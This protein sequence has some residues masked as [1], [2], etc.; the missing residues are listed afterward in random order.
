MKGLIATGLLVG[1]LLVIFAFSWVGKNDHEVVLNQGVVS[2]QDVCTAKF[3][4][5]F[6]SISQA[7]QVPAEF[8]EQSKSAFKEIYTPLIEGR[9]QNKDG[10]QQAVM[11]K[12]IQESNPT[13]DLN[14]FSGMYEKIQQV[15]E[16][17][18]TEFFTEQKKLISRHQEHTIFVSTFM[19]KNLFMLANRKIKYC[20]GGVDKTDSDYIF[21]LQIIT[22]A[23]TDNAYKTGQENDI[24]VF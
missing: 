11:M 21:C 13:F 2:Q 22:S 16:I 5:M 9:Y 24:S 7:A 17:K 12:W 6:K 20:S 19:N 4:E 8:M 3:D 10:E 1:V 15:I 23:N 14:A 18:R